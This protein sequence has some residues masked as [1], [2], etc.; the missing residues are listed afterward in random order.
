[1]GTWAVHSFRVYVQWALS[2]SMVPGLGPWDP[3]WKPGRTWPPKRFTKDEENNKRWRRQLFVGDLLPLQCSF[4]RNEQGRFYFLKHVCWSPSLFLT[5]KKKRKKETGANRA[6]KFSLDCTAGSPPCAW[7]LTHYDA[8]GM[9]GRRK[10]YQR[11]V[12]H[13]K[14]YIFFLHRFHTISF[15]AQIVIELH[16]KQYFCLG[17]AAVVTTAG[18]AR[19]GT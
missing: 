9:G 6:A 2:G 18:T 16:Q 8:R 19:G 5:Q 15:I 13:Q 10:S 17:K 14:I 11:F 4:P 3:A 7:K 1:M 12:T